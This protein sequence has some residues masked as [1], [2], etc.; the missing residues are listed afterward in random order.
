MYH[1]FLLSL[2][3]FTSAERASTASSVICSYSSV[4]VDALLSEVVLVAVAV[5]PVEA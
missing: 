3:L 1:D 4:V 2:L 5:V